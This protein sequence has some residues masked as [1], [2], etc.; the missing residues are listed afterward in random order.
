VSG[1]PNFNQDSH[2][3]KNRK[4]GDEIKKKISSGHLGQRV[5][6]PDKFLEQNHPMTISSK[7]SSY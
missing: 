1:D 6:P 3:A 5:K 7:F 2:Q 4:K